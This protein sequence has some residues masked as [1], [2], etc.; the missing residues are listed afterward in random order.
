MAPRR[1]ET[2]PS[3]RSIIRTVWIL[4]LIGAVA[5]TDPL[6][7]DKVVGRHDPGT[8]TLVPNIDDDNGDGIPDV[9]AAPLAAGADDEMFQVRV[10]PAGKSGPRSPSPGP[11][12]LVR[13]SAFLRRTV[14]NS[15]RR[16]PK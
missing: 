15:L 7:W 13:L 5:C 2:R 12:S 4:G 6:P 10:V 8:V 11:I 9:N 16:P 1:T 14:P 3:I